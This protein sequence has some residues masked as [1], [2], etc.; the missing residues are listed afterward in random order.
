MISSRDLHTL[1]TS[2]KYPCA[3]CRKGARKNP[4]FC[5]G[6]SFWVHK[7][8]SNIPGILVEDTDSRCRRC[9]GNAQAIDGR[10]CVE[11][12]LAVRKLD[13][14]E[15]FVY[16]GDS[17]CQMEVVSLQLLKDAALHGENLEKY[18]PCLL[19]KQFP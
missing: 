3:V 17:T 14:V 8:C 18:Y 2:G 15:N 5:G 6:C 1:Q 16:L 11:I 7:K 10:A 13:L 12:Q 19:V 9:L 4:I